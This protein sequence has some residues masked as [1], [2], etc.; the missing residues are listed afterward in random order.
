M[1]WRRCRTTAELEPLL[2]VFGVWDDDVDLK[3]LN[4]TSPLQPATAVM[5]SWCQIMK[6]MFFFV[7]FNHCSNPPGDWSCMS[8]RCYSSSRG[9][10][11][12]FGYPWSTAVVSQFPMW[13]VSLLIWVGAFL[14]HFEHWTEGWDD[15]QF[16]PSMSG[17]LST[18]P[19]SSPWPHKLRP[20]RPT[21]DTYTT[22]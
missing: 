20:C 16:L 5:R 13:V 19:H 1:T 7:F 10:L 15:Q 21:L 8:W 9:D 18:K 14:T 4:I 11:G 3:D 17:H 2:I 12:L 6:R 22:R